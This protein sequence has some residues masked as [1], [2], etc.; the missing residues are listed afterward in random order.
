MPLVRPVTVAVAVLCFIFTWSNFLHDPLIYLFD[1]EKFTVPLGLR[2]LSSRSHELPAPLAGSV[3]AT[4]PVVAVF[5][6]VQRYFLQEFRGPAGSAAEGGL[7][8]L[9]FARVRK[10]YGAVRA[11]RGLDLEVADGEFLVLVGP[12]GCGKARPCERPPGWRTSPTGRSTS[13]TGR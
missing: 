12:S 1:Q 8:E 4:A 13:A 6:F 3:V 11:L 7:A 10:D 5:I 9:R 2:A